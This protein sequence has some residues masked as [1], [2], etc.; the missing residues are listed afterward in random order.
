MLT[1]IILFIVIVFA[2]IYI[3][4]DSKKAIKEENKIENNTTMTKS[5]TQ[6]SENYNEAETLF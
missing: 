3:I 6:E 5:Q 4:Y 2:F 1:N